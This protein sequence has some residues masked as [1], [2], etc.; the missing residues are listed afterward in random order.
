MFM[1]I[2]QYADM[3]TLCA[4]FISKCYSNIHSKERKAKI[5]HN[6]HVL[7]YALAIKSYSK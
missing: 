2:N 1:F 7:R 4:L 5:I 3:V 6:H